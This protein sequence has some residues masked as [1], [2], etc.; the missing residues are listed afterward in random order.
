[1]KKEVDVEGWHAGGEGLVA[2]DSA[3]GD[4]TGDWAV[5][6][7]KAAAYEIHNYLGGN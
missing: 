5:R 2:G 7:G 6:K 1:M 3:K 4:K